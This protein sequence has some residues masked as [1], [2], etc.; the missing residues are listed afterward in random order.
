MPKLSI[1]V[2]VYNSSKYLYKC[3]NSL[4]NQTLSDMEIILIDDCSTDN[5]LYIIDNYKKLYPN[6]I[7]VL[8]NNE[9]KGTGY[10]RNK[11]LFI[12]TGEYIGFIDS[13]DYI[14][15][16]MYEKMYVA[17]VNKDNDIV[18]TNMDLK[19]SGL[20]LSFLSR[21]CLTEQNRFNIKDYKEYL[22]N[23]KPSCCNKIY[24]NELLKNEKFPEGLKW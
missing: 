5:S 11:G 22:V 24:R 12:A 1:I 19:Y 13:D 23:A 16:D 18:V 21:K 2:P 4:L 8:V 20:D 15:H 3:I 14:E 17:A 9:N 6:K 10:S 7:K